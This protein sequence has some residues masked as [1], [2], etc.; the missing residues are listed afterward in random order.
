[1]ITDS[2]IGKSE[3]AEYKETDGK[4]GLACELRTEV[5]RLHPSLSIDRKRIRKPL[6]C[7]TH[8]RGKSNFQNFVYMKQRIKELVCECV[9]RA[10][11]TAPHGICAFY[12]NFFIDRW[13]C[14]KIPNH[15]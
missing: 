13:R 6:K 8:P 4:R 10:T 2:D 1:M 12:P 3:E 15:S 9:Q 11:P 14:T 5:K 7:C